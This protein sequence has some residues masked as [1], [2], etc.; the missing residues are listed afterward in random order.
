MGC[1]I[2]G[3]LEVVSGFGALVLPPSGG[4][5]AGLRVSAPD[6]AWAS[7]VLTAPSEPERHLA[8]ILNKGQLGHQNTPGAPGF[9]VRRAGAVGAVPTRAS[10]E[11]EKRG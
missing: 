9:S 2:G 11:E 10:M 1:D 6:A 4:R 5:L 7:A 8:V 3:T